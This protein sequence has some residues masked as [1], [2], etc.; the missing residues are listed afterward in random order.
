MADV[1]TRGIRSAVMA[2]IKG[3]GNQQTEMRMVEI[4]RSHGLTGWRRHQRLPGS[5]DFAFRHRRVAIFVDGCFWHGCPKHGRKPYSNQAYWL[6]KLE[7]TRRRDRQ[8][9]RK[10]RT[11][12]WQVI[13]FWAHSLGDDVKVVARLRKVLNSANATATRRQL[14]ARR[15]VEEADSTEK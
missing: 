2:A 14:P 7:R 13:R 15:R 4:L 3:R 5:P 9:N 10:L 6:P 12:G 11:L 8:T 1:F